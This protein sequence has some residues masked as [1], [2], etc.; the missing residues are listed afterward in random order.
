M[1]ME[2]EVDVDVDVDV[3]ADASVTDG[4]LSE[5]LLVG[6]QSAP[7]AGGLRD[8]GVASEKATFWD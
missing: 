3:A 7:A 8:R 6:S 2:V 1:E 4:P 5:S